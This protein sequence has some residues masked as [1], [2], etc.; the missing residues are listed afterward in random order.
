M[1]AASADLAPGPATCRPAGP[2]PTIAVF[3][4]L[5]A[6]TYFAGVMRGIRQRAAAGGA[7][8]VGVQTLDAS[9]DLDHPVPE[10]SRPIAWSQLDGAIV[11]INAV[12]VRY[13]HGL[14]R[15][16]K[17]VVMVS[18]EVD[19][20]ACPVVSP[21]NRSGIEKAVAH[22]VEHGHRRIAFAG[23]LA[24]H[25]I[26]ERHEAYRDALLAHGIEPDGRLLYDTGDNVELG[27]DRAG[28]AMLAAGLPST[29]LVAATDFNAVGVMRTL[30]AAGLVLPGDQAIVG[31][32]DIEAGAALTPALSSI[33]QDGAGVGE[34]A[35]DLLLST[36]AGDDV[37]ALRHRVLAA[38]I[39]RE[40]CGCTAGDRTVGT[41]THALSP[42]DR[43]RDGLGHVLAEMDRDD[44]AAALEAATES[45]ARLL[46]APRQVAPTQLDDVAEVLCG[47]TGRWTRV[48]DTV[49][50]VRDYA[51]ELDVEHPEDALAR[52]RVVADLSL[53]LTAAQGRVTA[54]EAKRL[55]ESLRDEYRMSFELLRSQDNDPR[56][57]AF[58]GRTTVRVACLGLWSARA[59][60]GSGSSEGSTAAPSSTPEPDVGPPP[61]PEGGPPPGPGSEADAMLEIA[62]LYA[63]D[64]RELAV[65]R[66]P[67]DVASFP[68]RSFVDLVHGE[69]GEIVVVLPLRTA[70]VDWG[71]L[72]LIGRLED[73][74]A[75]GRDFYFQLAALLAS[76]LEH[77]ATVSS[78]RRQSARLQRSEQRYALAATAASEGLFDWDIDRGS[79]FCSPRFV[80]IVEGDGSEVGDG[81]EIGV[82][83]GVGEVDGADAGDDTS[84]EWWFSRVHPDDRDVLMSAVDAC[85]LGSSAIV[86]C[87]LRVH[88][89]DDSWRWVHCR[90]LAVPGPPAPARRIVGSLAD[91]TERRMLEERLRHQALH[92]PLTGL[93]NRALLLDRAERMLAAARRHGGTCAALFLDLDDFKEINDGLG[94]SAGDELLVAVGTRLSEVAREV[95]TVGRIGGDE[96]VVLVNERGAPGA[97]EAEIV[98]ERLHD[99]MSRPFQLRGSD[100]KVAASIGIAS[101]RDATAEEMLRDADI[102]MYRAKSAGKDRW[103][104]FAPAMRERQETGAPSRR[105][106]Q[107]PGMV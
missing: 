30:S 63:R 90:G 103:V 84:P 42:I 69:D 77:D 105:S 45:I 68:P 33:R 1:P 48:H 11:I 56:D 5:L 13:L 34:L 18:H 58:L 97:A 55:S 28:K 72:A 50:C 104:V 101:T 24:Q 86:E 10:I 89:A 20:F 4:P 21:D 35:L 82:G 85:L 27:G 87:E 106:P 92:D 17:P 51:D 53:T 36:L 70:T 102:A 73:E 65:A 47:T 60:E 94:H 12:D 23:N 46:A 76:A 74:V 41:S 8:V 37:P 100:Y 19:G 57:L 62:S 67:L 9:R 93:A 31:F 52:A 43:L 6:G 3:S 88:A 39:V 26:R 83:S 71:L 38:L 91:V 32:D 44:G 66:A 16:G 40:S 98:A 49:A 7:V 61:G 99:A 54:L 79:I 2:G 78:L 80:E 14:R 22:L 107:R 64:G 75:S 95:D 25:D 81:S 15:A 59:P 96:F 29:A